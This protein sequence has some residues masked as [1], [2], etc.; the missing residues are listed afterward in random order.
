[1]SPV[2]QDTTGDA[3]RLRSATVDRLRE[4]DAVVA[5][6]VAP[7]KMEL[8]LGDGCEATPLG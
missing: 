3:S 1:M 6:A 8:H 7:V 4:E 2:T 5:D